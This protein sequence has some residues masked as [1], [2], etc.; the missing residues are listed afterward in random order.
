MH[1][2]GSASW[3][4]VRVRSRSEKLAAADLSARR[5]TV[6]AATA[7]LR[8]Q[9][10][11]RVR[12]VEMPLF[13]GYVF[14]HFAPASRLTVLRAAGVV[15]IVGSGGMDFPIPQEEMDAVLTLVHSS[16]VCMQDP[17][18]RTGAW[19]R[20]RGGALD[21]LVGRLRKVKDETR[22]VVTL[23]L[24]QRSVSVEVDPARLEVVSVKAA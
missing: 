23:D 5:V 9:W 1:S 19:V 2:E 7:P 22:V 11:D 16:A 8:R 6:C 3:F 4:A 12:V 21:G 14:A 15:G 20:V 10:S 17:F 13:P 24:L 18:L